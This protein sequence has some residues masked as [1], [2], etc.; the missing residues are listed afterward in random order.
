MDHGGA[1][2][3]IDPFIQR[4]RQETGK[5]RGR[6]AGNPGKGTDAE[7]FTDDIPLDSADE[8]GEDAGEG[9]KKQTCRQRT[10]I[11]DIQDHVAVINSDMAG[12]NRTQAEEQADG[13]LH[14]QGMFFLLVPEMPEQHGRADIK[15]RGGGHLQNHGQH[16]RFPLIITILC[17]MRP[18]LFK[19]KESRNRNCIPVPG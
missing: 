8:P 12:N 6:T 15:H 1:L 11:P 19:K 7:V 16:R 9:I 2:S 10:E 4:C 3:L 18:I 17:E 13:Q 14:A 5:N